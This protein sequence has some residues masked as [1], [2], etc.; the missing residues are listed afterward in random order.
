MNRRMIKKFGLLGLTLLASGALISACGS[1]GGSVTKQSVSMGS[2][3][4]V[5]RLARPAINEAL[6]GTNT[7]LN[8]W[9]SVPPSADLSPGGS[10]IVSEAGG[11]LTAIN[12][13]GTA[14]GL[15]PPPVSQVVSGFLPDVMRIDTSISI[16]GA[17]P[18]L[19]SVTG[20]GYSGCLG[21]TKA[22]LCGGRK[23][24]DNVVQITVNYLA[25]G[26]NASFAGVTYDPTT[27]APP[28]VLA[29]FPYEAAPY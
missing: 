12:T 27:Q 23:L 22:I 1:S 5:E 6:I 4:Q 14:Q 19:T 29:G 11:T 21:P 20:M 2:Y 18:T 16:P 10:A 9:N 17:I 3:T 24:R 13:Y 25:N 7:N 28:A 15:M 26:T 8:L